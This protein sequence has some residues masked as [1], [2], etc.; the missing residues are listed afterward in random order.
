MKIYLDVSCLNRPFD[1]QRQTRIRLEAEAV[2]LVMERMDLGVWEQV[3]SQMA[4]LEVESIG[5]PDRKECVQTLL[6]DVELYVRLTDKE[7]SRAAILEELGFK[8]ADALHV[9][10]AETALADVLLSCDD[11][12]CRLA[13][14]CRRQLL[15]QVI[16]PLVWLQELEHDS[17]A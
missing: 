11:R 3:S 14:R 1:D 7:F 5:D 9:A 4:T 13:K 12:L 10:A 15:V 16:N 2:A 8:A 17:N 6:E